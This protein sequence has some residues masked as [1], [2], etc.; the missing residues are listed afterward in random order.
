MS[1]KGSVAQLL[2]IPHFRK[3]WLELI[4]NQV[5][6]GTKQQLHYSSDS[7]ENSQIQSRKPFERKLESYEMNALGIPKVLD[8]IL[9]YF[10]N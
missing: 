3:K 6:L 4:P 7:L 9:S 10:H 5:K 1:F 8:E 2:E